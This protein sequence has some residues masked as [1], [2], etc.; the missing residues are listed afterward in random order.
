[1]SFASLRIQ[2]WP[3]RILCGALLAAAVSCSTDHDFQVGPISGNGHVVAT[4]QL[5]RPAGQMVEFDGRPVDLDITP[6]GKRLFAKDHRGL[7]VIDPVTMRILQELPFPEGGPST[8]GIAV[9][10]DGRRVF[11]SSAQNEIWEAELDHADRYNW[12]RK[13]SVRGPSGQGAAHVAG[14]ALNRDASR[15]LAC[16]SRNNSLA[17]LDLPSGRLLAEIPTGVAPYDVLLSNDERF[18]FVSNWGG[19]RAKAEDRTAPSSGTDTVVDERGIASTGTVSVLDLET[20]RE[21]SQVAT[22]LHPSDLQL[23]P[24]GTRLFVANANSDSVSVID[25]AARR[26]IETIVVRPSADLPFGSAPNALA[27]SADGRQLFVANG[28]NNAVAVVSL[29]AEKSGGQRL[30]GFI[31]AAWYP[32]A[33]VARG[34]TLFVANIKGIGSRAR[35]STEKGWNSHRHRGTIQKIPMPDSSQ[36]RALTQQVREDARVPQVLRAW[37][38]SQ[39]RRAPVPVPKRLGDPSVFQ[40]VVYVIKENRTYDQLFGDLPQGNGAPELCIFGREVTPNHHAL[41][42]QFV[43]LDNFY[44]NGVLSADGHAWATEG[45]VTDY[46]EK[47]FGGFTRSYTWGDDPI[48]SSSSGFIWDNVLAHGLSFRNYGE[49]DY[50][51]PIPQNLSF[52]SMYREFRAGSRLAFTQNIGIERLRRYSSTNYPGWNMKIP[53]VLRAARFL[54]ELRSAEERNEFANLT[55]IFLPNDHTSGTSP[56]APTPRAQVADNDLALGQIV[57]GITRS[58]FWPRTCIFVIEDDPQDGFDHVDGHRSICLVISPYTKR[59]K[60]ISRFYNQTSVLHTMQRILGLPPM[61]QMDAMS[62][63]MTECFTGKADLTP[64]QSLPNRVPLDELNPETATLTGPELHWALKSLEQDFAKFDR[65]DEDLLNRILWHSVKGVA[66]P[67]PVH[68]AG[69]HGRG[70]KKLGLKLDALAAEDDDDD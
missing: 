48:S 16:L 39:A 11:V 64:Y 33:L 10:A 65:A 9:S 17:V 52:E 61:N 28:G 43:L 2:H 23:S 1:M 62:P 31:P 3:I 8:H 6:D 60:V 5:I 68:L 56:K 59:G 49:M 24:D 54:E 21:V 50:A 70:L 53:D 46:L 32:G 34:E 44:C 22:E 18:A 35:R 30:E 40:H 42:E 12:K 57:E 29:A 26:A 45:N 14:L 67:Y 27:L 51:E 7:V 37:E 15:L 55:I 20:Q 41:A 63:L 13:I 66:A 4:S 47:S 38:R 69:S 36:L 19:R 25:V 58:R